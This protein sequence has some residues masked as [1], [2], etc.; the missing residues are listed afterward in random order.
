MLQVDLRA[1]AQ[2]PV[3][4]DGSLATDDPMFAGSDLGLLE[5]VVVRGRLSDA[6]EGKYY[7]R[8]RLSTSVTGECR[9]CLKP[10][11]IPIKASVDAL[12]T[13]DQSADDPS[14]YTLPLKATGVDLT[15]A[16]REELILAVPA[17]VLCQDDCRGLCPRCGADLN[18]G[19]CQCRPESDPRWA[20]LE[21]LK[22]R[23]ADER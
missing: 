22:S 3:D 2:G 9:R 4:T 20:A 7:W 14:V 21:A 12:F 8:G 11:S 19:P 10:V 16:V 15:E 5:A 13:E 1:L 18:A 23:P 17:Y 6:G